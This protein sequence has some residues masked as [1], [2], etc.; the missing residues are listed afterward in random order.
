MLRRYFLYIIS[1]LLLIASFTGV[2]FVG[3]FVGF[4]KKNTEVVLADVSGKDDPISDSVD[5]GPFWQTWQV[6]DEKFVDGANGTSTKDKITDQDRVWGA[7][8]G[9]TESLG[10]PYTTFFPPVENRQFE[11]TIAG[12]FGGVGMEVGIKDDQITVI[13]PLANTPAKKAGI[14]AGDKIIKVDDLAVASMSLDDVI[15]KIRGEKGTAVRLT[16]QRNS[17][18]DT[19]EISIIRDTINIPTIETEKLKNGVFVIRLYNFSANSPNLFRKALREFLEAKTDKLVLDL[20]GNPGGYLEAAIDMASWFLPA[21]KV[22]V[23]EAKKGDEE[24]DYRSK[25]YDIFTDNLKMVILVDRG[26]ASASEILAGALKEHGK[27]I[28]VGEKTFGK[29]SVQE[30]ISITPE[31]S[32]KV[33]VARWLTP[34][35]HSLSGDGLEPDFKVLITKEDVL[36]GKDPQLDKAIEILTKG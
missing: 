7:I 18:K 28:L 15:D 6:L 2:F 35:G 1:V 17:E 24:K 21:D 33:T 29:G 5:F 14:L 12:N 31:T 26:S 32:L 8:A 9:M 4:E 23:Y 22:V 25:G 3:Y 20:R 34:D 13:A 27:A 16:I 11:E 10:D 19:R 36:A 30:L